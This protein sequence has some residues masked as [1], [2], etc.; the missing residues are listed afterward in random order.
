MTLVEQGINSFRDA[1]YDKLK[2]GALGS[3][4]TAVTTGDTTIGAIISGTTK[5]LT[6]TKA[7]K[8]LK[9]EYTTIA[10]DGDGNVA[11]EFVMIDTD[12]AIV[13][14]SVYPGITIG[15]ATVMSVVTQLLFLQDY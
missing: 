12:D 2:D 14:R 1:V 9:L 6:K 4:G 7:N 15:A 8:S 11:R 3:D 13:S 5:T 10:G